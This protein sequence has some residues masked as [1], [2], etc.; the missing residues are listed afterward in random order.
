MENTTKIRINFTIQDYYDYI[1]TSS[2]YS[3]KEKMLKSIPNEFRKVGYNIKFKELRIGRNK[4][5]RVH[6]SLKMTEEELKKILKGCENFCH[7]PENVSYKLIT[8]HF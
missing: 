6:M 2:W 7:K 8:K 5:Y 1:N 3:T 4:C